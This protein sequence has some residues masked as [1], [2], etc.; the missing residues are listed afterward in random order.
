MSSYVSSSLFVQCIQSNLWPLHWIIYYIITFVMDR[1]FSSSA[2]ILPFSHTLSQNHPTTYSRDTSKEVVRQLL[3]FLDI[4]STHFLCSF[5]FLLT[6]SSHNTGDIAL[7]ALYPSALSQGWS[8]KGIAW[9]V[10]IL[11]VNWWITQRSPIKN[12]PDTLILR[13]IFGDA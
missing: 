4:T 3:K 6:V 1:V 13:V 10:D 9:T 12:E 7:F 5:A 11:Q 2:L 8:L